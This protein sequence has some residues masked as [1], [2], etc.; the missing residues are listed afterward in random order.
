MITVEPSSQPPVRYEGRVWVRI[1][2]TNQLA[3][4]EEEKRLGERRRAHDL[5]FDYRAVADATFEDLNLF[6]FREEY[7]PQA[8]APDILERNVRP[9]EQQLQALRFLTQGSPNFGALIC[10]GKDP[11]QWIPG[12]YVQ[13]L[14]IDGAALTDPIRDQKRLSGPMYQT[15]VELDELL[16]INI[17]TRTQITTGAREARLPDY[18]IAA[19]QQLAR[20]AV[21]HRSYEGTNAPVRIYWFS[22]RV[23]IF[24]PGSL[25]GQVNKNN[26][27][28][29]A[30]DYRNPLIAEFMSTLGYVQKFG[31]GIPLAKEELARN[32]NPDPEFT[33]EP[34]NVLVTVRPRG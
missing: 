5:P 22:D 27:G 7:L 17:S 8:V 11:L 18:P 26:F 23:E 21:M 29:G 24:N 13:V 28:T 2:S 9:I 14:R 34:G 4:P 32:G 25:Y 30:T 19:L 33:F 16:K 20:N 10:M 3:S 6:Y 15:L 31:L 1:G 12:A